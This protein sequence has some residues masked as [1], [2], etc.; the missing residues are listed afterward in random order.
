MDA[1]PVAGTCTPR[2]PV[3][4]EQSTQSVKCKRFSFF[5][6]FEL[7]EEV[8]V[9]HLLPCMSFQD[10]C[11][12][13]QVN[14]RFR[15]IIDANY[16]NAVSF[17]RNFCSPHITEKAHEKYQTVL[18]RWLHQFG[19]SGQELIVKLDQETEHK[20]FPQILF[21]S[22]AKT[23]GMT[24]KLAVSQAG[25]FTRAPIVHDMLFSLD[26]IHAITAFQGSGARLYRLVE[27]K[28]Q[29]ETVI[30][31]DSMV[32]KFMF[33]ADSSEVITV[34]SDCWIRLHKF[35]GNNW[36]E[37]ACLRHV[38]RLYPSAISGQC[39]VA[40]TGNNRIIIYRYDGAQWQ[41]EYDESCLDQSILTARFSPDGKHFVLA[42]YD[43]LMYELVDGKWQLRKI[44]PDSRQGPL[45][46]FSS[47]G[48][49]LLSA[50]RGR[51]LQIHHLVAGEWQELNTFL[52]S[53]EING[54]RFTPDG[55][56]VMLCLATH[57]ITF[58][59]FVNGVWQI[60]A[61]MNHP[62][63]VEA[64]AFSPNGLYA[65]T[66]CHDNTVRIFQQAGGQWQQKKLIKVDGRVKYASFSPCGTHI[67]VTTRNDVATIYGL[68]NGQ[69]HMKCRIPGVKCWSEARFSPIGGYL[70]IASID[71]LNFFTL[72]GD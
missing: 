51:K 50:L 34:S 63:S 22:I 42:C 30:S 20:R 49:Q 26:G 38:N 40:L 28:W 67:A 12:C 3:N 56:H 61:T 24:K 13:A 16:V 70:S 32:L 9:K 21:Y 6:L 54:F 10:I 33:S 58:L 64:Y 2:N 44:I 37:Q 11:A 18:R 57:S 19:Q 29:L 36:Q 72:I 1:I 25:S 8:L 41:Q 59:S 53:S 65:I 14:R 5:P 35:V 69:W 45:F 66:G 39:Q 52:L 71:K 15:D 55:Q 31:P 48:N 17:C 4:E 60:N 62:E 68:L 46:R 43:L 47:D 27:E 23:L 7:P